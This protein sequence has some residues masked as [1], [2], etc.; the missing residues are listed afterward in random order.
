MQT[1]IIGQKKR[2]FINSGEIKLAVQAVGN[3]PP[4]IFSHGLTSKR[5]MTLE[6]LRPLEDSYQIIAYD[7]RGHGESTPVNDPRL[8]TPR[9]M[10]DDIAA[11]MD[12]LGIEQA[13]IG[14]ES[15]GAAIATTFALKY[16]DRVS[17]LLLTAPAFGDTDNDQKPRFLEIAQVIRAHGIKEFVNKAR[18]V[19]IKQMNLSAPAADLLTDLFLGHQP[20]SL[21]TAMESVIYW[22][23]FYSINEL[24]ALN[25]PVKILAW[26]NDPLHPLVLA[27]NMAAVINDVRLRILT[28]PTVIFESPQTI[29]KFY[30]QLLAGR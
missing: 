1:I 30:R 18:P 15:M 9:A 2:M 24:S 16:P 19:W 7:Q 3:G 21:A 23:P 25:M 13:I 28:S 22:R 20:E 6:Q 14:G 27:R 29:G 12:T 11:L 5:T 8:Y 10:A 4:L 17:T 26:E